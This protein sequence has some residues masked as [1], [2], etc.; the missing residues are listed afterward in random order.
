[1][2]AFEKQFKKMKLSDDYRYIAA[3]F[4]KAALETVQKNVDGSCGVRRCVLMEFIRDEL[5]GKKYLRRD[6]SPV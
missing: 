4:W 1:M 5:G 6:T 2:E 3:V